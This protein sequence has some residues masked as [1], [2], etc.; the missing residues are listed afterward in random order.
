MVCGGLGYETT[1]SALAFTV[2]CL[3]ANPDK[4]A[5]LLQARKN[6]IEAV[7]RMAEV[8]AM[9]VPRELGCHHVSRHLT[10]CQWCLCPSALPSG[11]L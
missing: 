4:C 9:L 7:H 2:Y 3:A 5:K 1:A 10:I 6:E 11:S 8:V